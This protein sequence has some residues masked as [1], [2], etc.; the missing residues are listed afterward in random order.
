MK[1]TKQ[2][3]WK[4]VIGKE[5]GRKIRVRVD[6]NGERIPKDIWDD[7]DLE[8][9]QEGR[10]AAVEAKPIKVKKEPKRA[11]TYIVDDGEIRIAIDA[12]VVFSFVLEGQ[13]GCC[14][15]EEW[16]TINFYPTKKASIEHEEFQKVL[17]RAIKEALAEVTNTENNRCKTI[18]AN[19]I[20][21]SEGCRTLKESFERTGDFIMAREFVNDNTGNKIEIWLSNN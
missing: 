15:I 18:I 13:P 9:I 17:D 3:S 8:E 10:Q 1:P 14:G 21:Q 4:I 16:H 7:F 12:E 20:M 19:L 6:E 2:F 11:Y 5:T